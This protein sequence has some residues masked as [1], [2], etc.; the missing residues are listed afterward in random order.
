MS[1]QNENNYL[2]IFNDETFLIPKDFKGI[3]KASEKI[4]EEFTQNGKY[5]VKSNVQNLVFKSFL[6][7]WLNEKVPLID[8]DTIDEY[9]LLI[10]E[11]GIM[12][13]LLSQKENEI[14]EETHDSEYKSYNKK[15]EIQTNIHD[16]KP[17]FFN[18]ISIFIYDVNKEVFLIGFQK[19]Y[20]IKFQYISISNAIS[21]KIFDIITLFYC[22]HSVLN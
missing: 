12:S 3:E 1:D 9:R 19:N 5:I 10:N 18:D 13:E 7:Y 17:N 20:F 2:L 15:K 22:F 11:F 21:S 14:S 16:I 6:D 8:S 4:K